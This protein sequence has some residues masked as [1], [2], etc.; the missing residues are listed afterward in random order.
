ML[1]ANLQ[2]TTSSGSPIV[3]LG[4]GRCSRVGATC[5][6]VPS[7][8]NEYPIWTPNDT[9]AGVALATWYHGGAA[10]TLNSRYR[11]RISRVLVT[12]SGTW[13]WQYCIRNASAGESYV[14]HEDPKTWSTAGANYAWWG[15]ETATHNSGMGVKATDPDFS[16]DDM[17][18]FSTAWG[19][20]WTV[21]TG[22]TAC[23]KINNPSW[24]GCGTSTTVYSFDTMTS[25]TTVH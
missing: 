21:R 23:N 25:W 19:A 11:F 17:Q 8:G 12:A 16:M 15:S 5:G 13:N 1:P 22:L 10:L 3:Q 7:N 9:S 2:K 6:G 14:C 24:Y 20:Q 18:Y 4:Y